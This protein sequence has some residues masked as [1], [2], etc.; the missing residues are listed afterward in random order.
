MF[1][2]EFQQKELISAVD[3]TPQRYFVRKGRADGPCMVF[4]HGH[5][6]LG[7]QLMTRPDIAR[8]WTAFLAERDFSII[9]PD[10]RGN[11]WMGEPAV[12]DLDAMLEREKTFLAWNRLYLTAGSMGGTGALIFAIRHPERI[13]GVAAFGA[14]TDLETYGTW[15]DA[16]DAPVLR[17]IRSAIAAAYPSAEAMRRNSVRLHADRLTM[18][19]WY[20]HG[21]A[22]TVIPVS[23]AR[24]LAETMRGRPD[25]HYREIDGGNHDSPLSF[26][27]ETVTQL[28]KGK[29]SE[30]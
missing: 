4:L 13:D 14:A 26:Y 10:L 23:E 20:L 8:G 12:A 21:G 30:P 18:P 9:S 5:G 16:Q 28:L 22:D 29:D 11:A 1:E 2:Q 17:E 24:A 19:V 27:A 15:L 3:G 25:F 6:S 7:D